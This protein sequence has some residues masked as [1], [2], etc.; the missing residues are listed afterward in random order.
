VVEEK[1]G[2]GEEMDTL[3]EPHIESKLLAL[4]H[5][6][7]AHTRLERNKNFEHNSAED[8]LHQHKALVVVQD[9][10]GRS[11]G[12]RLEGPRLMVVPALGAGGLV[13]QVDVEIV[14]RR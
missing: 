14:V 7:G 2:F 6:T 8:L 1:R 13:R 9:T 12:S 10:L 3:L 4:H 5:Q 11:Q